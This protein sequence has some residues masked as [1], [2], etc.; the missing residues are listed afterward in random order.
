MI[1]WPCWGG[2]KC[3][4]TIDLRLEYGQVALDRE[5]AAFACHT[6]LFQFR[7]MPFG[8]ANVPGIFQQF[9]HIVLSRI[10]GFTMAYLDNI[11]VFSET[12]KQHFDY[13]GQ[14]LRLLRKHSLKMKLSKCQV[15][16]V[17]DNRP[18][19]VNRIMAE[20]LAS[21]NTMHITTSP[22]HLKGKVERFH[23]TQAEVLAKLARENTENWELYL[24]QASADV[25]FMINETSKFSSYYMLDERC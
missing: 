7:V 15:Q 12:P 17:T 13:V 25:R 8:R 20:V 18:E 9:M 21:L 11:L 6:G 3:Y 14:V 19:N 23:R 1:Y 5:M 16:L 4:S 24:T 2:F 10:E 22:Y